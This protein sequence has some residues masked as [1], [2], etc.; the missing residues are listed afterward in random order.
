MKFILAKR[1]AGRETK[2]TALYRVVSLAAFF[3]VLTLTFSIM[4]PVYADDGQSGDPIPPVVDEATHNEGDDHTPNASPE[5]ANDALLKEQEALFQDLEEKL[6]VLREQQ[7]LGQLTEE[8]AA[9][10][11]ELEQEFFTWQTLQSTNPL[12]VEQTAVLRALA[13]QV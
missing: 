5:Q 4:P 10:L 7:T 2:T 6:A 3:C 8:Q 12:N 1:P 11:Q 9:R 13:G